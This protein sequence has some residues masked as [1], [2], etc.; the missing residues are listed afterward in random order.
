MFKEISN[1]REYKGMG[2]ETVQS[3][4]AYSKKKGTSKM[5]KYKNQ[6]L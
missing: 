6:K 4:T 1:K 2:R 5:E 3:D